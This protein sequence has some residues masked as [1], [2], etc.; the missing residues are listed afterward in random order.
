MKQNIFLITL[1]LSSAISVNLP[2]TDIPCLDAN[3]EVIKMNN[4][5]TFSI[6]YQAETTFK[7]DSNE[8]DSDTIVNIHSINCKIKINLENIDKNDYIL[9]HNFDD[10]F[11]IK[12]NSE[13]INNKLIRVIPLK[14]SNDDYIEA[15]YKTKTCPLIITNYQIKENSNLNLID[16]SNI[17]FD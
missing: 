16:N 5:Q 10:N 3:E 12:I 17:Y 9:N 8:Y 6:S 2:L 1:L 4:I 15:N 13:N 14:Y 11:A 7:F